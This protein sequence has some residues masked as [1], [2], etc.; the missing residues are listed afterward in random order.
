MVV[1][2]FLHGLLFLPVVLS[3]IGPTEI[4]IN[5]SK[6]PFKLI[7]DYEDDG[8]ASDEDAEEEAVFEGQEED[9]FEAPLMNNPTFK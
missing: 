6:L 9:S 7:N 5:D 3:F 1:I 4:L 8:K 2:G